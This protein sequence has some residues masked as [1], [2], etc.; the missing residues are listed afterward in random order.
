MSA[1]SGAVYN[2]FMVVD[3][4][5]TEPSDYTPFS[6]TAPRDPRLPGG[7]GYQVTGLLDLNPDKVGQVA[8][9][10]SFASDFGNRIHNWHGIDVNASLRRGST[11]LQAGLSTGRT[12]TDS[13]EITRAIPESIFTGY[14]ELSLDRRAPNTGLT[15]NPFCRVSTPFLTQYKGFGTFI[16]PKVDV[17]IAAT[18]QSFPG[19]EILA[20]YVA[21]NAQVAPSLGRPLSGGAANVTVPL[22][23]PGTMYGPRSTMVD[24]RLGKPLRIGT[25]RATPSLDIYNLFNS[26]NVTVLSWQYEVWQRPQ[27]IIA[28]R[29]FKFS[30]QVDF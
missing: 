11:M 16:V 17:L 6:I 5:A 7:G 23:A 2:N 29:L 12:L 8:N 30:A 22:I 14:E 21:S 3:N 28:G 10:T 1:T 26:S 25:L 13:C 19:Q 20:N 9:V 27:T 15:M 24:L 4:R 18:L